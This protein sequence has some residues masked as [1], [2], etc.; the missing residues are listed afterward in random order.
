MLQMVQLYPKV[1]NNYETSF[2][3][4]ILSAARGFGAEPQRKSNLMHFSLKIW[5]LVAPIC[6]FP[7][8]FPDFSPKNIF[9]WPFSDF[10]WPLKFSD[11]FQFSVTCGN[12]ERVQKDQNWRERCPKLALLVWQLSDQEI[13]GHVQCQH[14]SSSSREISGEQTFHLMHS[15]VCGSCETARPILSLSSV[16]QSALQHATSNSR[17]TSKLKLGYIIVRSKA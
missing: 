15:Y 11:F 9:P 10:P 13:N 6:H 1:Y 2:N 8:L 12:P 5:D 17:A 7:W 4:A 3:G 16:C 14:V